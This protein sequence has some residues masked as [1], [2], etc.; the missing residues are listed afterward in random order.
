MKR[1][2]PLFVAVVVGMAS[3]VD[4]AAIT[5]FGVSLAILQSALDLGP[6][7]VG[8]AAASLTVGIALGAIAGGRLGDRF[9]RRPVFIVTMVA[10]ATGAAGMMVPPSAPALPA[11]AFILGAAIGADLPVSLAA[12]SE[13]APDRIRGRLLLISN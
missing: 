5:G 9:G 13:A 12:I 2:S 6:G 4:A 11:V 10:I 1:T 8:L 3:Y 7:E